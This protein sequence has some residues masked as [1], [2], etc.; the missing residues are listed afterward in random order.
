MYFNYREL[1]GHSEYYLSLLQLVENILKH[2]SLNSTEIHDQ[3]YHNI[4]IR[5]RDGYE[6]YYVT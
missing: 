6:T 2:C 3:I 5:V 1:R 4:Y